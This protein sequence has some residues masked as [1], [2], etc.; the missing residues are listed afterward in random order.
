[1][2]TTHQGLPTSS[3]Q[4]PLRTKGSATIVL[5]QRYAEN[6]L[7]TVMVGG[8]K[9]LKQS[10]GSALLD[11]LLNEKDSLTHT[12]LFQQ[13]SS[14]VRTY[15]EQSQKFEAIAAFYT[16]QAAP[17]KYDTL[18]SPPIIQTT[19]E[20]ELSQNEL[21]CNAAIA[22]QLVGKSAHPLPKQASVVAANQES[23]TNPKPANPKPANPRPADP[24]PADPK[25]ADPYQLTQQVMKT[26]RQA[27]AQNPVKT[28]GLQLNKFDITYGFVDA[29]DP[30]L[31]SGA[32]KR[33]DSIDPKKDMMV[34]DYLTRQVASFTIPNSTVPDLPSN[35]LRTTY[36]KPTE[37]GTHI[38]Q[39]KVV[40]SLSG[41][42]TEDETEASDSQLAAASPQSRSSEQNRSLDFENQYDL[43]HS[44]Q[45][46]ASV[47]SCLSERLD[48]LTAAVDCL[49][50][51]IVELQNKRDKS[52]RIMSSV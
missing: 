33:Q 52:N 1:M 19:S 16:E 12:L 24:R 28:A 7:M 47:I 9:R 27:I 35:C 25:L 51:D 10:T 21:T 5:P 15:F 2:Q 37:T 22:K 8:K 17:K 39:E 44:I 32:K 26:H 23:K 49:N 41:L 13:F 31:F 6:S 34:F 50:K 43:E 14:S 3:T 42:I 11:A 40:L 36:L 38:V 45:S 4:R 29:E 46:N 20:D 30:L 48:L 18:L